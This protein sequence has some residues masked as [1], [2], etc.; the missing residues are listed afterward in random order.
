MQLRHRPTPRS[1]YACITSFTCALRL[2]VVLSLSTHGVWFLLAHVPLGHRYYDT[3]LVAAFLARADV[4]PSQEMCVY[5][6]Y[7]RVPHGLGPFYDCTLVGHLLHTFHVVISCFPPGFHCLLLRSPLS[8]HH[9]LGY[10]ASSLST[11]GFVLFHFLA[12]LPCF[13]L[14]GVPFL[15]YV[16]LV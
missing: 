15:W 14:V 9:I 13:F 12:R 6:T 10:A 7:V 1:P 16:R 8:A 3:A 4:V 2:G 11:P 5:V